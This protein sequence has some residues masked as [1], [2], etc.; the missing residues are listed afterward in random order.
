MDAATGRRVRNTL[1][2]KDA[3]ISFQVAKRDLRVLVDQG[4]LTPQGERRARTY[5]ASA[6]LRDLWKR[7]RIDKSIEDPFG[8]R[9]ANTEVSAPTGQ[10]P[11]TVSYQQVIKGS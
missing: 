2:R 1:Y 11:I 9:S 10:Q 5:V 4:L 6:Y 3:E 8:D 7:L